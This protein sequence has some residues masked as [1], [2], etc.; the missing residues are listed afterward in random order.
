MMWR[1]VIV[2]AVIVA[3]AVSA[4][5]LFGAVERDHGDAAS[6][7]NGL[8]RPSALFTTEGGPV[9][10]GD[11]PTGISGTEPSDCAACHAE[12]AAEWASSAHA[13]AWRDPLFQAELQVS[14]EAPCRHCHAPLVPDVAVR[15]T[16]PGA[17]VLDGEALA[18][19]GIDCAVCHVRAGH[20]FGPEGR[21][22]DE[23]AALR[24]ARLA[25][26]AF[27]GS[28]HQFDFPAPAPGQRNR[29]HPGQPLQNTLV[30]WSQSRYADRPCQQCHM[31]IA[32]E[33]GQRHAS[34]AFRTLDDPAF[35]ARAVRVTAKAQRHGGVVRVTVVISPAEI[36]HAFP[37]GDMFRQAVLTVSTGAA[38]DR[39]IL[40]RY[41][42][43]TITEDARG[44]L[45]GQVDDTRVPPPRGGPAP[46]FAFELDDPQATEVAWS[47]ELFRLTPADARK[48]GFDEAAIKVPV[49]AGRIVIQPGE[50]P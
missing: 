16:T 32:G 27:C 5:S 20:V 26:S 41:F 24:D 22:G 4:S 43:Q 31:P 7:S 13:H 6:P 38:H 42:A 3:G 25:T 9:V 14:Q 23:H 17:L 33:A 46:R 29:Y 34:H 11:P 18:A 40:T 50:L 28:C 30:E 36:G 39:E 1:P 48:R 19:R 10:L 15:G 45:L 47:L 37:T 44:H 49:S 21:G 12:I 35:M 2:T 8:Q